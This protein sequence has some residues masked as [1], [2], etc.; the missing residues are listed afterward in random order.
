MQTNGPSV[1]IEEKVIYIPYKESNP[2]KNVLIDNVNIKKPPIKEVNSDEMIINKP[3]IH[4]SDA[5]LNESNSKNRKINKSNSTVKPPKELP[6]DSHNL[7]NNREEIKNIKNENVQFLNQES[8][9]SFD[10]YQNE[11]NKHKQNT[12]LLDCEINQNENIEI[13]M[14]QSQSNYS[15]NIIYHEV[16]KINNKGKIKKEKPKRESPHRSES[17]VIQNNHSPKEKKNSNIERKMDHL[18]Q[19]TEISI[20]EF[21]K[22]EPKIPQQMVESFHSK[23]LGNGSIKPASINNDIHLTQDEIQIYGNRCP[24]DYHKLRLLGKGGYAVV[25]LCKSLKDNKTYALKQFSKTRNIINHFSLESAQNEIAISKVICNNNIDNSSIGLKCISK[26]INSQSDNK[27]I[28]LAYELGGNS[29]SKELF[30]IRGEFYNNER[31]YKIEHLKLFEMIRSNIEV[32]KQ[33][34]RF[35]LEVLEVLS[36]KTVVHADLKCENILITYDEEG[37]KTLKVIDF[38]SAFVLDE[39]MKFSITTPE[40]VSPECHIFLGLPPDQRSIKSFYQI[41]QPWSIDMWSV[42]SI[43]LEIITGFPIWLNMKCRTIINNKSIFS[44]VL[45]AVQGKDSKKIVTKQ[46]EVL[47]DLKSILN[48]YPAIEIGEQGLDLLSSMLDFNP[49]TRISPQ[50]ALNHPFLS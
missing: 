5:H 4:N 24:K 43:F 28:W 17:R 46:K 7:N 27:D 3:D 39:G 12:S 32:L 26:L 1:K 29:L 47:S 38:G 2:Q 35:L 30:E 11:E 6:K 44:N 33:L 10:K 23:Y 42:G 14:P 18:S 22:S 34:L 21:N 49:Q 45:F 8:Q 50:E 48:K 19:K 36:E 25:W 13:F 41:I 40:Y 15:G 9:K 37:I 16:N 31:I 20:K